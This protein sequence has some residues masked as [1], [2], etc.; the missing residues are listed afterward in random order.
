MNS[1]CWFLLIIV[2]GGCNQY[3]FVDTMILLDVIQSHFQKLS[4]MCGYNDNQLTLI[5]LLFSL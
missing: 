4:Q 1:K 5:L 3:D 2:I